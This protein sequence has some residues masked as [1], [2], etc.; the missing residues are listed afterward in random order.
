LH[1]IAGV[2]NGAMVLEDELFA[3]M[4]L[5]R[6]RRVTA[7]KII[8]TQPLDQMFQDDA[9]LDSFIVPSSIASVIGWIG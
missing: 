6:F 5:E 4:T 1:P 2:V 3:H 8:G 9:L 7:P